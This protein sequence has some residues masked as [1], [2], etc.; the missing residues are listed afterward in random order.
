MGWL[1]QR[2]VPYLQLCR[3]AAVFTAIADIAAGL[4][5]TG[6]LHPWRWS[7]LWLVL[8]TVG[9][10]LALGNLAWAAPISNSG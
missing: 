7:N 1:Q 10:R 9:R 4:A 3:F 6:Q 5:L 8:A 2:V